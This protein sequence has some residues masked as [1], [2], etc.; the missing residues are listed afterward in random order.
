MEYKDYYKILGVSKNAPVE[1]IKKAYRKLA[2]KYHP[3][4]NPGDKAAEEKFKD[5]NEA[6]EVLSDPEKRKMY[7]RF[8]SAYKQYQTTGRPGDFDWSQ[9]TGGRGGQS[10]GGGSINFEDLFGGSGD[11]FEILF[12]QPSA[13]GRRKNWRSASVAKGQDLTAEASVT[14]EEAYHGTTRQLSV[15]GEM[16]KFS[17]KPGTKDRQKLKM[18]GKGG[19]GKNDGP[20]GDLYITVK[21]TPHPRFE[22]DGDNLIGDLPVDIYT[23]ILGG[24]AEL[25]TLKGVI[26]VDI[27]PETEN[28]KMLRLK[29]MGMPLY[30]LPD[31]FGDLYAKISLKI[32]QNLSAEEAALFKKLKRLRD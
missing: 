6:K 23:A 20:R 31:T 1:E 18:S 32:P 21:V 30:G 29:G 4:K 10:F 9:F 5:I 25:K 13:G 26:K 3:D 17:I 11:F 12:G 22:R 8:G 19:P 16:I 14:L 24:K 7:E 2:A 28:G 15:G 27:P